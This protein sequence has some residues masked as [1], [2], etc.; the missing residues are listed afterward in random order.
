MNSNPN[1]SARLWLERI[2]TAGLDDT[3]LLGPLE[4]ERLESMSHTKRRR[5]FIA[6]RA[7][8]HRLLATLD[9]AGT[10]SFL[11]HVSATGKPYLADRPDL[12]ISIS[13]S[14]DWVACAVAGVPVGVDIERIDRRRATSELIEEVCSDEEQRLIRRLSPARRESFFTELWTL[15]EAWLKRHGAP[16]DVARMRAI[17][18]SSVKAPEGNCASWITSAALAVSV[19]GPWV[20]S[21]PS[22]APELLS[23]A[24]CTTR[25][26]EDT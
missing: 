15:K 4:L 14:G 7:L 25:Q 8:V 22:E 2:D 16:L 6:G 26:V 18:W 19:S 23:S 12:H 13:H 21:F 17:K 1:R 5:Q 9:K 24:S 11:I 10:R 20:S 3:T